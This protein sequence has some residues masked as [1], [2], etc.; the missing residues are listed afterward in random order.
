MQL[1]STVSL[2]IAGS[3]ERAAQEGLRSAPEAEVLGSLSGFRYTAICLKLVDTSRARESVCNPPAETHRS[4][5]SSSLY[6]AR[7][8]STFS[9]TRTS[10]TSNALPGAPGLGKFFGRNG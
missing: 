10:S 3:G 6:R 1:L 8:I 4:P 9:R 5:C 2:G 7:S